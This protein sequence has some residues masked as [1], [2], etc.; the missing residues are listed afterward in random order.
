MSG[1]QEP[2]TDRFLTRIRWLLITTAVV[3]LA[4]GFLH[5]AMPVFLHRSPGLA[6][7]SQIEDDFVLLVTFSTGIL[8][9]AFGMVG[10][11]LAASVGRYQDLL[12]PYLLIK[13]VLWAAR[14]VLE[15]VLPV[16]LSM[17]WIEPF[18]AVAMPGMVLEFLLFVIAMVM[19]R[20][21]AGGAGTSDRRPGLI[22]E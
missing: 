16:R 15:I 10:L 12:F 6:E 13:S 2:S 7:L 9:V 17:F 4:V 20:K 11:L 1:A 18:T 21:L 22:A 8:L 5:F 14:L 3:E 19:A